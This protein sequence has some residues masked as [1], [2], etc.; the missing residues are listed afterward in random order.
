MSPIP[1]SVWANVAS[2]DRISDGT[3][4]P[5]QP[6]VRSV[7]QPRMAAAEGRARG[8]RVTGREA[9]GLGSGWDQSPARVTRSRRARQP[10]GRSAG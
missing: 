10:A 8:D 4:R 1:A 6:I 3:S 2:I 7:R 5:V 9:Y